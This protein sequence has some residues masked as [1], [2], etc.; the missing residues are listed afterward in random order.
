M[1]SASGGWRL[2]RKGNR[3]SV[4]RGKKS[5]ETLSSIIERM[6]RGTG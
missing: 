3:G 6:L 2:I 1:T 4:E 5:L